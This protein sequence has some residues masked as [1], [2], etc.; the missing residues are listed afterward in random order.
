MKRTRFISALLTV[1]VPLMSVPVASAEEHADGSLDSTFVSEKDTLSEAELADIEDAL[2]LIESIPDEVLEQGDEATQEWV[3]N[4]TAT[5]R[6]GTAECTWAITKFIGSNVINVA[7][8]LKIKKYIKEIG[9]VAK[10]VDDIR[11][12]GWSIQNIKRVGGP[13]WRLVKEFMGIQEIQD[14]CFDDA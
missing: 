5:F 8:I 4:H 14:S 7:K 3:Q 13:L 12:A 6:A 2:Y 11:K 9:G 1:S 10:V